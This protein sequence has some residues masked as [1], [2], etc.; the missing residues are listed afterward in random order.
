MPAPSRAIA[1]APSPS[2]LLP[3]AASAPTAAPGARVM[4]SPSTSAGALELPSPVADPAGPAIAAGMKA[5]SPSTPAG[6]AVVAIALV[7]IVGITRPVRRLTTRIL[8]IGL[9]DAPGAGLA[10]LRAVVVA[11]VRRRTVA[12]S[13]VLIASARVVRAGVVLVRVRGRLR[14]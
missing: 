8:V 12:R 10:G 5:D 9:A 11:V 2:G 14:R 13:P 7:P 3:V 4:V 1:T 6:D